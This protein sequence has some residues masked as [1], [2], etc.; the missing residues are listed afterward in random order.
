[1]SKS[2]HTQPVEQ[3]ELSEDNVPVAL[4]YKSQTIALML[5]DHK[6]RSNTKKN[7]I[8]LAKSV[9]KK[10]VG[11]HPKT[12]KSSLKTTNHINSSIN[13]QRT[14]IL[15]GRTG[16]QSVFCSRGFNLYTISV[17]DMMKSSPNLFVV[18]SLQEQIMV[19][20]SSFEPL[21]LRMSTRP[22]RVQTIY[23]KKYILVKVDDY[24]S[25]TWVKFF[26]SKDETPEVI[27]KFLKQIQIG[28]NKTV[29]YI[30]TD[31]GTE[32]SNQVLTEYYERV[33]IFHQKSVLETLQQNGVVERRNRTLMEA[34]RIMLIFSKAS[35]FLWA[36]VLSEPMAPVQLSTGLA[37]T[38]LMH[39]QISSRLVPNPVPAAPYV[40][41]TNKE[42]ENLFQLMFDEY[43]K[44][45]L[46]R[47]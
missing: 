25:F 1:M 23:G 16:T 5:A 14:G 36:E 44:S 41:P 8:F 30:R 12:N 40:P 13:S 47:A 32:F 24:S 34:A 11:E 22:M 42:L 26:R 31:N 39:G 27:I 38:F 9:N 6:P 35:M 20:T 7:R 15:C 18:Q 19:V 45:R 4:F 43:L 2:K 17:K 46:K 37:P 33:G 28:L 21:E 29:R 3:L 10:K